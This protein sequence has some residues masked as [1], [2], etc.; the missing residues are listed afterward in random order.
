MIEISIKHTCLISYV[1][2]IYIFKLHHLSKILILK[3]LYLIVSIEKFFI[4]SQ[5]NCNDKIK[6]KIFT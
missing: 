4:K 1:F 2:Q 3:K 6:K 5:F